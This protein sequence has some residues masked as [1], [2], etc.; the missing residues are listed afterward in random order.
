[1][2]VSRYIYIHAMNVT[3]TIY[4]YKYTHNMWREK[5]VRVTEDAWAGVDGTSA[6]P[7]S[8]LGFMF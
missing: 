5:W 3:N 1:M 4:I 6:A 8:S 7:T 2:V